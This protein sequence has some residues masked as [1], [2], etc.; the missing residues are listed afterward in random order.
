M[1]VLDISD[2]K[3]GLKPGALDTL[4]AVMA[5]PSD[6]PAEVEQRKLL[7]CLWLY[8]DFL[9]PEREKSSEAIPIE[10]RDLR[11]LLF[12]NPQ[13]VHD[14][15][16]KQRQKGH[17]AGH[18]LSNIEIVARITP[19]KASV[20][21]AV[22][23]ALMVARG[24]GKIGEAVLATRPDFEIQVGPDWKRPWEG[25]SRSPR[26]NISEAKIREYWSNFKSVSH[27]WAAQT[28]SKNRSLFGAAEDKSYEFLDLLADAE[29][30][31]KI[32]EGH[33]ARGQKKHNNSTLDPDATWKTP[34]DLALPESLYAKRPPVLTDSLQEAPL[35]KR[36]AS[37]YSK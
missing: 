7:Q 4:M 29:H 20:N 16:E 14:D 35:V 15:Y 34:D 8:C 21:R 6:E 27:F 31:R 19:G 37:E 12:L 9:S 25:Q 24:K 26:Y 18:I 33:F 17:I 5:Y 28:Y 10:I 2:G 36:F 32:G 1:P 23:V 13:K 3:G 30:L 11:R 22:G